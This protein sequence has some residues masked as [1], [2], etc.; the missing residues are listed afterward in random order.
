MSRSFATVARQLKWGAVAAAAWVCTQVPAQTLSALVDVAKAYDAQVLAAQKQVDAALA[1]ADQSRASLLPQV[2]LG[3]GYTIADTDWNAH[4]KARSLA[5]SASQSLYNQANDVGRDQARLAVEQAHIQLSQAE[6]A[7]MANVSQAYFDLL[8]AKAQLIVI[9]ASKKAAAEQL[10]RAKRNFEVGTATITDTHEAQAQYDRII[11]AEISAQNDERVKQ[12]ALDQLVGQNQVKPHDLRNGVALPSMEPQ[13]VEAWVNQGLGN[14]PQIKLAQLGVRAAELD[15][16]KVKAGRMPT[17]DLAYKYTDP[18]VIGSDCRTLASGGSSICNNQSLSL[19]F[20]VP[21]FTGYAIENG[22]KAAVA[23]KASTEAQMSNA[24]RSVSQN[25]R[26]AYFSLLSG[27]SQIKA[28]QAA[29][30]SSQSAL[31]A[32]RT[33]YEVGVRINADVLN[34]QTQLYQTEVSLTTARYN[35][36]NG[37]IKLRQAAGT[38]SKQDLEA[39]DRLLQP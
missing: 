16:D 38:L 5:L 15:I 37:G 26:Q 19:S 28:L 31:D 33:G 21:L 35:V 4:T 17:V 23:N 27:T 11:A 32:N 34:A 39:I 13:N 10:A 14:N 22:V 8:S 6:Q 12:L 24:Q 2:G 30:A 1:R 36:L 25:I 7:L 18:K 20:S 3:G 9:A 29:V